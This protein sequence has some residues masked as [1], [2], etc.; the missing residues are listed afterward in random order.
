M[1]NIMKRPVP[2]ST[3]KEYRFCTKVTVSE[4]LFVFRC[5]GVNIAGYS[6]TLGQ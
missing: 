1:E 6:L 3:N 2:M 4:K 5:Y